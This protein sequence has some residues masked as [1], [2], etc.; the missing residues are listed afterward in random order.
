MQTQK[1]SGGQ[2]MKK[3]I[4]L[5]ALIAAGIALSPAAYAMDD[6]KKDEGMKKEDTMSTNDKMGDKEM[7]KD[8]KMDKGMDK[9]AMK[10]D[11]KDG[12]KK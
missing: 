5:S 7:K 4:L 1:S 3:T 8:E 6:M 11:S 2:R 12:M 9:G 10:D